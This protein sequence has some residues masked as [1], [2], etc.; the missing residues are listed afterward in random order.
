MTTQ[1]LI[2]RCRCNARL[3][4]LSLRTFTQTCIVEL[5]KPLQRQLES[6]KVYFKTA[7]V[8]LLSN[9]T[10]LQPTI[11]SALAIKPLSIL[12]TYYKVAIC[13]F[14]LYHTRNLELPERRRAARPRA[15]T[16]LNSVLRS[17]LTQSSERLILATEAGTGFKF[18]AGGACSCPFRDPRRAFFLPPATSRILRH[19]PAQICRLL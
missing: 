11:V 14:I 6:R 10:C 4:P 2:L 3:P 7:E 1:P 8:K 19:F 17:V 16:K 12:R 5:R 9:R 15:S 13:A 18:P